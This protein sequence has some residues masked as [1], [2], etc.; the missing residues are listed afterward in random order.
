MKLLEHPHSLLNMSCSHL[1]GWDIFP[2]FQ[3]IWRY[4]FCREL[5]THRFPLYNLANTTTLEELLLVHDLINSCSTYEVVMI[6]CLRP[7]NHNEFTYTKL[8][9]FNEFVW[10]KKCNFMN[11]FGGFHGIGSFRAI[12]I[13]FESHL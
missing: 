7:W 13:Y 8:C 11:I 5:H 10:I 3:L 2:S 9:W 12:N 1:N 4:G 6:S